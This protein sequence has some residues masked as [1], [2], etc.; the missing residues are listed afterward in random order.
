MGLAVRAGGSWHVVNT[1]QLQYVKIGGNWKPMLQLW[2]KGSSVDPTDHS[3][4]RE[5]GINVGL[6]QPGNVRNAA[7][8]ANNHS[9]VPL[10]WDYSNP[11]TPRVFTVGTFDQNGNA[12]R[13]EDVPGTSRSWTVAGL[14]QNTYYQFAVVA[15]YDGQP[16]VWSSPNLRWYIG[17]DPQPYQVAVYG[18]AGDWWWIPDAVTVTSTQSG[19]PSSSIVDNNDGTYWMS[20]AA[21]EAFGPTQGEGIERFWPGSGWRINGVRVKTPIAHDV[22]VGC[23]HNGG[24]EGGQYPYN[25][26]YQYWR[27]YYI[28]GISNTTWT[29]PSL[30]PWETAGASDGAIHVLLNRAQQYGGWPGPRLGCTDFAMRLQSWQVIRYDTYYT[31]AVNSGWW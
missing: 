3:W 26:K 24:W 28:T 20:V 12:L 9:N 16:D 25:G 22:W 5:P 14:A 2:V 1:N 30:G 19:F 10:A 27:H 13:Y 17:Q 18:W 11:L 21:N 8:D 7:P 23:Y 6:G 4:H 15:K 29:E 31:A